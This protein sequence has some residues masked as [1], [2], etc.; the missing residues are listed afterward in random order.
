[1]LEATL[2]VAGY[3]TILQCPIDGWINGNEKKLTGKEKINNQSRSM[4]RPKG[5]ELYHRGEFLH[6]YYKNKKH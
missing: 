2:P 3:R 5:S 6:K 4:G 1:M